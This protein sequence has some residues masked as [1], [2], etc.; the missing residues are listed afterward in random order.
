[1]MKKTFV[2]LALI[3][4]LFIGTASRPKNASA[5]SLDGLTD[6]FSSV[7]SKWQQSQ[8]QQSSSSQSQQN[9]QKTPADVFGKI[10]PP[11]KTLESGGTYGDIKNGGGPIKF[12]NAIIT[13]A[14]ALAGIWLLFTIIKSGITII[15]KGNSPDDFAKAI[16]DIMF[17]VIGM[18]IVSMSY[19]IVRYVS[20]LLFGDA[21]YVTQPIQTLENSVNTTKESVKNNTKK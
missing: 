21:T 9:Q 13:F 17:A 19:I 3:S 20:Y 6:W 10:E 4:V 11:V 16:K 18:I 14:S 15:T 12:V 7:S 2:S 5:I 1:M 8:S